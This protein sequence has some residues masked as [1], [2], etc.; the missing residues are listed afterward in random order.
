ME[1]Y[2]PQY[3]DHDLPLVLLSGLGEP[4]GPT[5]PT[6]EN[7][8]K[9][10][11][12][13]EECRGDRARQLL[14]HFMAFDGRDR[15]WNQASLPPPPRHL[16]F[17]MK[18]IG[19]TYVLPPR[20]AAP[21]PQAPSI[22]AFSSPPVGQPK[23]TDLHS[24]LSPLSPGSP[25][26]HDGLMTPLWFSKHQQQVPALIL[27][28]FQVDSSPNDQIQTD[29]MSLK[30]AIARS[31][32]KTRF[33]AVLL[34]DTGILHAPEIEDQLSDIRRN[35]GLDHKTGFFFMPPMSSHNERA[36]FIESMLSTLQPLVLDYYRDLSKHAK[37]KKTQGVS[38]DWNIRYEIKRAVFAE[39]R[40]EMDVAGRHYSTAVNDM[41]G[42]E[43]VFETTA[44]WSP[45]WS[46]ARLL[47]DC[48]ALRAIR[49]FLWARLTTVAA[50]YHEQYQIRMRDLIDRRG[51]GSQ[52]YGWYAWESRWDQ[53][54]AQLIQR[55][56]L[57][58]LQSV[59]DGS[60]RLQVYAPSETPS[61]RQQPFHLL[62]HAGYWLRL[63]FLTAQTRLEKALAIPEE[64]QIPPA[65]SSASVVAQRARTYDTYLVPEPH[66]E[67]P[68]NGYDHASHFEKLAVGACNEFAARNQVR[69]VEQ[70][71][72]ALAAQLA[73][74]G[75]YAHAMEVLHPVW[76]TCSWRNDGWNKLFARLLTILM[77]C[78]IKTGKSDTAFLAAW[79]YLSLPS[80][81]VKDLAK[82]LSSENLA[83]QK[84]SAEIVNKRRLSSIEV[85]FAF[86]D[87][88]AHV[89]EPLEC[90]LI[91]K[92]HAA[93]GSVPISIKQIDLTLGDQHIAISQEKGIEHQD[94]IQA[95]LV[96][97]P[98]QMR[99]ITF[100][101]TFKE[102]AVVKLQS[103]RVV[104]D[105]DKFC[106]VHTLTDEKLMSSPFVYTEKNGVFVPRALQRVETAAIFVL[107]KPPKLEISTNVHQEYYTDERV[108]IT[109][110]FVNGEAEP[111]AGHAKISLSSPLPDPPSAQWVGVNDNGL[112][113]DL[114]ADSE[115]QGTIA[116]M[117][118]RAATTITLKLEARYTLES[119]PD[120]PLI[121]TVT[122]ALGFVLPFAPTY[123]IG[124]LLH[125]ED[126]PNYFSIDAEADGIK[127]QWRLACHF[128]STAQEDLILH[129]ATIVAETV[130][131]GSLYEPVTIHFDKQRLQ[132]G[133]AVD[134][135]LEF[136]TR[137]KSLD[138]RKSNNLGLSVDV[139]WS[140]NEEDK[141]V[142][143]RF[144]VPRLSLPSSEPRV[145]CT[146]ADMQP[147][148]L[149]VLRYHLENLSMHFLTFALTMEAND[150]F[151]FGG[152]KFRALSLSPLSRLCV[153][154]RLMLHSEVAII[155]PQLQV[156]DS[157][158]QKQLRVH[159]GGP[160]VFLDEK[161]SLGV[162]ITSREEGD[163]K[164]RREAV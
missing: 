103:A 99:I 125:S 4:H 88:E 157:Y 42:S 153:E 101:R 143:T 117:A 138:D 147:G 136:I 80:P 163:V 91:I 145:L 155:W 160:G 109:V 135:E 156:V 10:V 50:V 12:Y 130:G 124:P 133:E 120:T 150:D 105:N 21:L 77:Q 16:A 23:G 127:Q 56:A 123:T 52:Q 22:E 28:F 34:S 78:A 84:I 15:S 83:S 94:T 3:V 142:V 11:S 85:L 76:D 75:Q 2:P 139:A 17:H 44:S 36:T 41:F 131:E 37:R 92:S 144:P 69:F 73:L 97:R 141:M 111:I 137:K 146:L 49:C 57:S 122:L 29:I 45:R 90:Q 128:A 32:Y 70:G 162:R 61:D 54:M 38:P 107:P 20:K 1:T 96:L 71:R 8:T 40:Q 140:R 114:A 26:Y 79:E 74:L 87:D 31:G 81:P 48:M 6:N 67:F 100:Q 55:A 112:A 43:A 66:E 104:Y 47:C 152:P 33:A 53:I 113:L 102:S 121:K 148:G 82:F 18:A 89:S 58:T 98:D 129:D 24:P 39:F 116:L 7:G 110:D 60:D 14:E 68:G 93:Q 164:S 115:Y 134:A 5:S 154:Y 161:N 27:A 46:E 59:T 19:R 64:D 25:I 13:S 30:S 65:Q 86:V 106:L 118:S 132:I 108:C 51:K 151:A 95:D 119:D 158:Y 63:A 149:V 62:H 126:W 35:T 9:L 72:L 159:P